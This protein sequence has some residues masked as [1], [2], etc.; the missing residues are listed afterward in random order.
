[1]PWNKATQEKYKR[2]R[3]ELETT[4][5][6]AEWKPIEPLCRPRVRRA[7]PGQPI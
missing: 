6:D 4:L 7:V 3:Q 5:T 2:N 1:M